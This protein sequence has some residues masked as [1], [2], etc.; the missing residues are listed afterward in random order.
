MFGLLKKL[1]V[2]GNNPADVTRLALISELVIVALPPVVRAH[3][4]TRISPVKTDA[5]R[6]SSTRATT[7]RVTMSGWQ[8]ALCNRIGTNLDENL[9]FTWF[10]GQGADGFLGLA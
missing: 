9:N 5:G 4:R 3:T 1:R 2:A 10:L 6:T 8:A 7:G